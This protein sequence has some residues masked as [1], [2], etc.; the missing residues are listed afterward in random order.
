MRPF[1]DPNDPFFRRPAT[2]WAAFLVPLV[3]AG[4]EAWLGSYG[5]ALMVAGLAGYAGYMLIWKGPSA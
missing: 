1:I 2:R 4:F 3:W 5:W